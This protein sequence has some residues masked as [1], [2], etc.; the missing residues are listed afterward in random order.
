[1]YRI[2][3]E[4]QFNFDRFHNDQHGTAPF[5]LFGDFNFRTDTRGVI[6]RLCE[7][8][9]EVKTEQEN[10]CSNKVEYR[11]AESRAIL[12]L[13]KKEFCHLEHQAVFLDQTWVSVSKFLI[14][15]LRVFCLIYR[16]LV[17]FIL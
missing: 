5:F 8:L 10:G 16:G 11:D 3:I 1:M 4:F 15:I 17:G 9:N 2:L 14:Y 7:G 6:N 13:G 12:T